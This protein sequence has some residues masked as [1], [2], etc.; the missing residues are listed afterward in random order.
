MKRLKS[1]TKNI[2][3]KHFFHKKHFH[4]QNIDISSY[5][6]KNQEIKMK[7]LESTLNSLFK[8]KNYKKA[9]EFLPSLLEKTVEK[10]KLLIY[11]GFTNFLCNNEV[12]ST[13]YLK[14][15][16]EMNQK[17]TS[18]MRDFD[19]K[20]IKAPME[21]DLTKAVIL[22]I[23]ALKSL[24]SSSIVNEEAS[25]TLIF[26][27]IDQLLTKLFNQL[28]KL[29]SDEKL[30][31][32][33][34]LLSKNFQEYS[35][36]ELFN[37]FHEKFSFLYFLRKKFQKAEDMIEKIS[38][39]QMESSFKKDI[40]MKKIKYSLFS[41]NLTKAKVLTE[42][43]NILYP[44]EESL[45]I[46]HLMHDFQNQPYY[47]KVEEAFY[48]LFTMDFGQFCSIIGKVKSEIPWG[49]SKL[50]LL[51][52]YCYTSYMIKDFE[53]LE[54]I[55]LE[56]K[57]FIKE[58]ASKN[59]LNSPQLKVIKSLYDM[60]AETSK[61]LENGIKVYEEYLT[62]IND[63]TSRI[64]FETLVKITLKELEIE[65]EEDKDFKSVKKFYELI[66]KVEDTEFR[67]NSLISAADACLYDNS[68]LFTKFS[69]EALQLAKE[70]NLKKLVEKVQNLKDTF[71][72]SDYKSQ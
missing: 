32:K 23:E 1:L 38:L 65:L 18:T 33:I 2:N 20:M 71:K 64:Y 36:V 29:E 67:V 61:K 58:Y 15:A 28:I 21:K 54:K 5:I 40:I 27:S 48:S 19:E 26:H 59:Q 14:E 25:K 52:S 70:N 34:Q 17:I 43:L 31:E 60:E 50:N 42:E 62:L 30:E 57:T 49:F 8:E 45:E 72:Y 51:I 53:H 6:E 12:D 46:F 63:K 66:D 37:N 11:L 22:L 68:E 13:K 41:R 16:L 24:E 10:K 35:S 3:G 47:Y 55:I 56:C 39:D 69:D 44:N 7:D 4:F 9:I